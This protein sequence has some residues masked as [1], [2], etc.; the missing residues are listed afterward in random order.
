MISQL[1]VYNERISNSLAKNNT[2]HV[3]D[4]MHVIHNKSRSGGGISYD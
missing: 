2:I 1:T 3:M 4:H